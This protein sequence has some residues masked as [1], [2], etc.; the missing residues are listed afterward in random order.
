MQ[1]RVVLFILAAGVLALSSAEAREGFGFT[2]KSVT[3]NRTTPPALN[4]AARRVKVA[5][6]SDRKKESDDAATLKRYTEE[7]LL[8]GAGTLAAGDKAETTVKLAVDRLDSHETWETKES[9]EYRKTGTKQEWNSKKNRYETKDVYDNV[10]VTKNVKVMKASLSGTFDILDKNGKVIDSGDLHEDFSVKYDEGKNSATPASV[11]DDLMHR[12]ARTVGARL[13]PTKDRVFVIVPKGSFEA[14]IPMAESNSWDRYLAAVQ[15]VPE[16]RNQSQEAFRQY[17][18]GVAKEGL[19]YSIDDARRAAGLLQESVNHYQSAIELN[20]GEKIFSEEY[21]SFLSSRIGAPMARAKASLTAYQ[22]WT[23]GEHKSAA[24]PRPAAAGA[25]SS[26]P[27]T[28]QTLI[29][30]ARA[31]LT[32]ENLMLAID[33]ADDASFDASPNALITLAKGGVSRTVIAHMQKRTKKGR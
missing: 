29:D 15:S 14:F 5:A 2:K 26:G 27:M 1:K 4:M 17:A 25:K 19:A 28:N 12:A 11:E 20:P 7:V 33:D 21:N 23:A 8:A 6:T 22:S 30:M 13:V 31:G 9:T 24:A 16:N 18:L 10:P 32:D 3:M